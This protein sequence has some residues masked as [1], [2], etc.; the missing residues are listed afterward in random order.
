MRTRDDL[1]RTS[2]GYWQSRA[3]LTAV[4]LDVFGAVGARGASAKT[5]AKRAGTEARA[6]EMLLDA[7]VGLG[8]LL[9][10]RRTYH[11]RREMVPFLTK[12]PRSVLAMLRHHARLWGVWD[13]LTA[14]VREGR[15]PVPE[16][17]FRGDEAAARAFTHAMRDGA[18]R[19]A[20][21][22]AKEVAFAGCRRL[23]DLGGGPGVY[24][25]A[26]ARANPELEIVIVDLPH[27]CRV[28]RELVAE[29]RDVAARIAYHPADVDADPLPEGAD[30][31]FLSHVI[32]S[33]T[34]DEVRALFAKLHGALSGRGRFVVRDFFTSPDRT[35]PPEAA[36]F[37]LNMLVNDTGGRSYSA[38]EV[39][40]WL[41]EAGFA[42]V[43]HRRS[44][45]VPGTGY[46]TARLAPG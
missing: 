43:A 6:T 13:H 3:L 9:K 20:P 33:Q 40:D 31:A 19:L 26:F 29:E 27:V 12:G 37:A 30:A 32:H 17:G 16:G 14:A 36:L 5:V 46:V 38:R 11:L 22:V 34:E 45:L 1:M 41:R 28:G 25:A 18:R 7:L 21:S 4:E 8:V 23:L 24:A 35:R 10:R 44:R 42:S 39:G 15:P 2:R